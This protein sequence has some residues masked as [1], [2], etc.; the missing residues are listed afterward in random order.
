VI[1]GQITE[2]NN[3]PRIVT[4]LHI[5]LVSIWSRWFPEK[6]ANANVGGHIPSIQTQLK[7]GF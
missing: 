7:P 2:K 3:R 1:F 6:K 4:I 5:M